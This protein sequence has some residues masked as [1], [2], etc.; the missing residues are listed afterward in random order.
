MDEGD[1]INNYQVIL[2]KHINRMQ[3]AEKVI[4]ELKPKMT[5]F[6]EKV[7]TARAHAG[8]ACAPAPLAKVV[9]SAPDQSPMHVRGL[10]LESI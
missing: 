5:Q 1:D 3:V 9:S 8:A 6:H 10:L 2:K 7:L 4:T